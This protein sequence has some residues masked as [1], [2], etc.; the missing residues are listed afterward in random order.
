MIKFTTVLQKFADQGEKTGWTYIEIDSALASQLNAGVKKSFQIKG[1]LDNFKFEGKS[2][3]PMGNG[4][5][6]L[7]INAEMRKGLKKRIGNSVTVQMSLDTTKKPLSSDFLECLE[8]EPKA[9]EKFK[10]LTPS[11]QKY[12][13]NWIETAK[14]EATKTKRISMAII[15]LAQGFGFPEMLKMNR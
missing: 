4:N 6:I 3:L 10:S 14:T 9:L 12:F 7:A 13:S 15:A 5:F 11:H 2:L 8:D 1:M